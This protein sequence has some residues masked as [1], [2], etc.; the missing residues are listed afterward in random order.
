LDVGNLVSTFF[1]SAGPGGVLAT[2]VLSGALVLY[3]FLARWIIR[4]NK[5]GN[6]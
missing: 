4:G 2:L 6:S 5:Q 3:I 1:K